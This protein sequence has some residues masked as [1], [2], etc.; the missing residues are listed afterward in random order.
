MQ[1]SK[2]SQVCR[3]L[4]VFA[5]W[6]TLA[7]VV[8]TAAQPPASN[9][10][11]MCGDGT[12]FTVNLPGL[13]VLPL[14]LPAPNDSITLPNGC[15]I[16]A[17]LV[18]GYERNKNFDE[19]TF[20]KLA[21]FVSERN[22]YVHYAWWNNIMKEYMAGPAH[23][24]SVTIPL[25]GTFQANPGG[26]IGVHAVGFAP[27]DFLTATSLF[28][29][30]LP[31][32]DTQFQADAKLLLQAIRAHNPN[33]IIIVG[34]HSMGGEAVARLGTDTNVVI[35][36]L[37]PIDPVGNR[38][39]PV[40]KVTNRTYNWTRWRAAQSVWGGYRQADCI[41][42]GAF[43][44]PCKD[45]DSRLFH[46]EYRCEPK[47]VGP[48][49]DEPPVIATRAP[50]I[51]PGPWVDPGKRRTIKSN[52]RHLLHRWQTEAL[53][54][55]DFNASEPFIYQG[56]DTATTAGPVVFAQEAL[57]ENGLLEADPQ[58][59]CSTPLKEDPLD[60]TLKCDPGDGHGEIVGFRGLGS[61][62]AIP[63]GLQAQNWPTTAAGRRQKLVEMTTAPGVDIFKISTDPP[64]WEHEPLNPHLCMVSDDM[65]RILQTILDQRG[66]GSAPEDTTAPVSVATLRPGANA[67]GWHNEDVSVSIISADNPGGSGVRQIEHTLTGAQFGTMVTPGDTATETVAAEGT[68]TVGF[69]ATDNADNT[70]QQKTVNIK[71][72]KT[73]PSI[74]ATA[75]PLPN[76]NNWNKTDVLVS[77]P[78]S[79]EAGGSGIA[80]ASADV[81]VTAEGA[82]QEITG[83]AE[84]NAGNQ[85]AASVI[86][87][88][89]KTPPGIVLASRTPAANG[90]GWNNSDVTVV[91]DCTDALSGPTA[92]NVTQTVNKGGAAQM[93]IG[94]CGDLADNTASDTQADINI[95]KT[96]PGVSIATPPDG[97][98]YLLNAV[99]N[100]DYACTDGLSG[101]ASCSGPVAS[102]AAI[103]T[104]SVGEKQFK[105]DGNDVAGN[106]ASLTSNYSVHYV[107]SGFGN[108]IG[109]IPMMNVSNAGRTVPVKYSLQNAQGSFISSLTSF[110]SLV[111][112]PV[113]CDASVPGV[114]AEETHAAGSATIR[115][116]AVSNQFI[117]NWKTDKSWAGTCRALQLTLSDG[118][119]YLAFF[120]FK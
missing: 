53:F 95:D 76:G 22:G 113:G 38:T 28:P 108:P 13:N 45:F 39:R 56:T 62:G 71:I 24:F 88:I 75:S 90:A 58:K 61:Q 50:G 93:V 65:V 101:I 34:G 26:L 46:V 8:P 110:V 2:A 112:G 16:Y 67:A 91:W 3:H 40:G 14:G 80:T 94:T 118:T 114:L 54:P 77:F 82:D 49:L 1:R 89:D 116:D 87:N 10:N 36:L 120:Q 52:V 6:V 59:T 109:P 43:P 18:S 68:T 57:G 60:P 104:A 111:S 83:T 115:Y 19:L 9:P 117:Y 79:D 98:V 86:L 4:A 107:F 47:G 99:V 103:N 105:V 31:E 69:R 64:A 73:L 27:L 32:E 81:L 15:D 30:A 12:T 48:L 35:D 51:C 63:V 42:V 7:P 72:D 85:A 23:D 11:E 20:Y 102:G 97:A 84:D 78:A 119:Q 41:R 5:L 33:A 96:G 92:P 74:S 17:L 25:L 70:E 66:I 21:K 44:L 106:S 55:F 29:K 100:A 37:A